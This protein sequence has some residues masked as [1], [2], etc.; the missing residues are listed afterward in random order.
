MIEDK[1]YIKEYYEEIKNGNII[2]NKYITKVYK[3]IVDSIDDENS[4]FYFDALRANHP[5]F[6]I[7]NFCVHIKGSKAGKPLKLEL[8]QKAFV[9]CVFG[10]IRKDNNRRRFKRIFFLVARKHGKSL[11]SAAIALYSWLCLGEGDPDLF[12]VATTKDQAKETWKVAAK[13]VKKSPALSKCIKPLVN[14]M[15]GQEGI[16]G[17]FRALSSDSNTLDG[18]NAFYVSM[19]E[20]HAFKGQVGKDLYNVML[21]SMI[22][23]D[24]PIFMIITTAGFQR[25]GIFDQL[26]D[27]CVSIINGYDNDNLDFK[28]DSLL[29]ILYQL[30][31]KEELDNKDM[32]TKAN[33]GL[34]TIVSAEEIERKVNS[35]KRTGNCSNA[36]CK[37]F[38][39]RS[40]SGEA[41]FDFDLIN[42]KDTF[43]IGS[44]KFKYGIGGVDLSES[45][46]LTCACVLLRSRDPNDSTIYVE[47]MA[48]IPENKYEYNIDNYGD[49][50]PYAIWKEKGYLRLSGT[51][52][53][54]YSD[55][56]EWFLEI[57][58]KYNISIYNVGYDKAYGQYWV[59]EMVQY[60]G[61]Y[62]MTVVRQGSLTFTGPLKELKLELMD[63]KFNINNN[64][65]MM[66][67]MSNVCVEIDKNGGVRPIKPGGSTSSTRKIDMFMALLDAYVVYCDKKQD[68]L[69]YCYM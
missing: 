33:P 1:N 36:L 12:S 67:C 61:E 65:I 17:E 32:W 42:I 27:E 52:K 8:W 4:P 5:I 47:S 68:Y 31:S 49:N 48:W 62:A 50:V 58:N 25:D 24:E 6:F 38:N 45:G 21:D 57:Q 56:T 15:V 39:I 18:L 14:T 60:F 19:D 34:G 2:A 64:P 9:Q 66:W 11:L 40:L 29:P 37:H 51:N 46:D 43:D 22:A 28:D 26:Y 20:C 13:M 7:E 54:E 3:H 30:D 41:Y 53:I 10:I 69:D 35:E 44:G 55:V 63:K 59:K 16:D 23:R